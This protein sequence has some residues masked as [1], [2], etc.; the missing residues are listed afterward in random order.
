MEA[1]RRA[2]DIIIEREAPDTK[3]SLHQR[4]ARVAGLI[5][6]GACALDASQIISGARTGRAGH[7]VDDAAVE[8]ANPRGMDPAILL[9]PRFPPRQAEP[10]AHIVATILPV[11][12]GERMDENAIR[13]A[14]VE[15]DLQRAI[16]RRMSRPWAQQDVPADDLAAER[17]GDFAGRRSWPH[18]RSLLE[19]GTLLEIANRIGIF[20]LTPSGW[21]PASPERP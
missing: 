14:G 11:I 1:E 13:R 15:S 7:L 4:A 5:P 19:G 17:A 8:F 9:A 2:G 18:P 16:F 10:L 20:R 3:I 6:D 21:V 12:A